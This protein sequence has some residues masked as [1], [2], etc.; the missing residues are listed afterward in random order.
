MKERKFDFHDG[1]F[2]AAI[3]VRITPGASRNEISEILGDGTIEVRLAAAA[4]DEKGNLALI[5]FFAEVL[6]VHPKQLE[7]IAGSSGNDKLITIIDLDRDTVQ[8]RII[9][10]L[11]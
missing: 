3:T 9:N 6:Q 10:H 1:K 11:V 5:Q 7:I 4:G 8:E 2:G